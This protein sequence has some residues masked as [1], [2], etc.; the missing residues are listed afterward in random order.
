ME[1]LWVFCRVGFFFAQIT[2]ET[3]P[4]RIVRSTPFGLFWRLGLGSRH[5]TESQSDEATDGSHS[6]D[7][8]ELDRNDRVFQ[9]GQFDGQERDTNQGS[10]RYDNGDQRDGR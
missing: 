8:R 5:L 1:Y 6:N 9:D 3:V 2:T 7:Q 4:L 10:R